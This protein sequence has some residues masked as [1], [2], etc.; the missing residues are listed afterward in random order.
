MRASTSRPSKARLCYG[1]IRYRD[2]KDAKAA[3]AGF[4]ALKRAESTAAVPIR[5]YRC[6]RCA[7]GWH[8]TSTTPEQNQDRFT[9]TRFANAAK[10]LQRREAKLDRERRHRE[11]CALERQ[12]LTRPPLEQI[13][14]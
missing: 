10:T 6:H 8:L 12:L 7:G 3:L 4:R 2:R 9:S 1:K 5:A 11:Q 13:A 14:S